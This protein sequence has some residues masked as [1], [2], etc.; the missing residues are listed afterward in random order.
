MGWSRLSGAAVLFLGLVVAPM[1]WADPGDARAANPAPAAEDRLA[2]IDVAA[3][4]IAN[5][6][7]PPMP[8]AAD[9]LDL[10]L[11]IDQQTTAFPDP[12]EAV[13]R[14]TFTFNRRVDRWVI[15][16]VARAYGA[17]VPD[18]AKSGIRNFLAN[19]ATPVRLVNDLLQ[20]RFRDAGATMS[21]F[22]INTLAGF[23]GF[24]DTAAELG[25]PPHDSDFGETLAVSG[26]GSGPFLIVPVFG[27]TTLRDGVGTLVD[28]A[29]NPTL[30]LTAGVSPILSATI[31]T[32]AESLAEREARDRDLTRL[33]EGSVDFYAALRSAYYQNRIAEIEAPE[34]ETGAAIAASPP[35]P[36]TVA[37]DAPPP[38]PETAAADP[39][40]PPEPAT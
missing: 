3:E 4:P 28:T 39:T 24:V 22:G 7:A 19:L 35:S 12:F 21:R 31:G 6:A 26:V 1:A 11:E 10:E 27:P 8:S 40:P 32:G 20:G 18:L 25:I 2:A 9:D 33:E 38:S 14:R 36:E 30:Y 34:P 17:V 15:S 23:A 29:I 13:N 5:D 16:P 37:S